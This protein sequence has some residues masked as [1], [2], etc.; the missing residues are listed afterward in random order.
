MQ[1]GVMTFKKNSVVYSL[2]EM[3]NSQTFLYDSF[4]VKGT[5]CLLQNVLIL[6]QM[7]I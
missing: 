3:L 2:S 1:K 4:N 6:F 7:F 5:P